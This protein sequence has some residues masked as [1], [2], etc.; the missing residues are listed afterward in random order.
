[1]LL[2]CML[3]EVWKLCCT[4]WMF[5]FLLF[6]GFHSFFCNTCARWIQFAHVWRARALVWISGNFALN[7]REHV[8]IQT[9][10]VPLPLIFV[11]TALFQE[12][13]DLAGYLYSF[14]RLLHPLKHLIKA[15]ICDSKLKHCFFPQVFVSLVF[16]H[17]RVTIKFG[18]AIPK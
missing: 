6:C 4:D 9:T 13:A 14:L 12:A 17:K 2:F 18:T 16:A 3:S 7:F 5:L 15:L 8:S 11:W 1:M 10:F